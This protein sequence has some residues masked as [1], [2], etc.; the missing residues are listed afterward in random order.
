MIFPY[1]R[2]VKNC[3]RK[4]T[5]RYYFDEKNVNKVWKNLQDQFGKAVQWGAFPL[6]QI[7]NEKILIRKS[8]KE[9][10]FTLIRKSTFSK[11]DE[12]LIHKLIDFAE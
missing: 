3:I 8:L 1:R 2:K 12:V 10:S 4:D 9:N 6:F 7:E 5:Y 11:S